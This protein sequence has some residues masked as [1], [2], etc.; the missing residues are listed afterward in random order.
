MPRQNSSLGD[1][2]LKLPW[3]VSAALG[4]ITFAADDVYPLQLSVAPEL[5]TAIDEQTTTKLAH[6][7]N[8]RSHQVFDLEKEIGY[9]KARLLDHG[10]E[11]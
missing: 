11:P 6:L 2:L 4:L 7:L 8:I 3:W 5:A 1:T 9:L 10:I